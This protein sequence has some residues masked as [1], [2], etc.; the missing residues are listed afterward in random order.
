[1]SF[2]K[3]FSIFI[4]AVLTFTAM[5]FCA[6]AQEYPDE[7][8]EGEVVFEYTQ[9]VNDT[10]D[11]LNNENIPDE[12]ANVGIT[13]VKELLVDRIFDTSVKT[14]PDGTK[15]KSGYFVGYFEGDV[16]TACNE[17]SELESVGYS[18]PNG[19]MQEDSVT[20]PTEVTSP[21]SLY[22]TYTKWWFED[23]LNIPTAWEKFDTLGE[24]VVIAVL[25]SGFTLSN[26][27]YSGRI[28]ED[29]AGNKGYNAVTCTSEVSP[30]TGHGDNVAGIIVGAAGYN[31]S[32]IGVAPEAQI[33]P[34]KVSAKTNSISIS[35]V[36]TGINYAISNK[37]DI[38]SLSLSTT[39][40]NALLNASCEAAYDAGIIVLASASNNSE[41]ASDSLRYPAA[42]DCVIGVM[43]CGS[44]GELCDFSNYDPTLEYYNIAAPGYNI[45]G[46]SGS[47]TNVA[48]RSSGTSQATPIIA[49]LAALYLS[50]YPDHTPEEFRRSLMKSSTDTVT[51]NSAVVTDTTYTFPLVNAVKL[52]SYPNTMP[53]L[54]AIAGS[55]AVVDDSS[56][57]V[58]GID[59]NYIS[60]ESYIAVSD[61]SY[62]IIPTENGNGTGT[63]IRVLTNTGTIFRDYEIVI[64]GD[65]DGD[66][67]CDGRDALLCDYS[68]AGGAVPDSI[69]FACD[70]DFDNDVDA[71][72]SGIIARCG[73]FTDFVSQIR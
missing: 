10:N 70:V 37:A 55:T 28:W 56:S 66:A 47:A 72:D 46:I 57:L 8:V 11:F 61:G 32:L 7:Y 48:S 33:M 3:I 16:E 13:T 35:A 38:I 71:D 21:R 23:L 26:P 9:T 20:I 40:A 5:P 62:Q 58:Y 53:T 22:N 51:S 60:I 44:D 42:F 36:I 17:L 64:F 6:T 1:M 54:Y 14:N 24:G 41:S 34:I 27:E 50:I 68:V 2:K 15:T 65:T 49:G 25:D 69:S 39:E 73:V 12:L 45:L 63:I 52:L 43:A 59:E 18:S 19:L 29:P 30:D 31:Y 67:Q 4:C